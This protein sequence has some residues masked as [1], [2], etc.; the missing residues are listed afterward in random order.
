MHFILFRRPANWTLC[1]GAWVHVVLSI[2]ELS[3]V[4]CMQTHYYPRILA[5]SVC[6]T[7]V[8]LTITCGLCR[9]LFV[10]RCK[11]QF[12]WLTPTLSRY[13]PTSFPSILDASHGAVICRSS[14]SQI[15]LSCRLDV[16]L[17]W[18]VLPALLESGSNADDVAVDVTSSVNANLTPPILPMPTL[19]APAGPQL[20]PNG[21]LFTLRCVVYVRAL[22]V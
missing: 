18:R 11:H 22:S 19:S 10:V 4:Q 7:F 16:S 14:P 17:V 15:R 5:H 20:P 1:N 2:F 21:V 13:L 3:S 9:S 8:L 12:S 6:A